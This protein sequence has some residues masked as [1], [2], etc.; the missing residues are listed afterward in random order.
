MATISGWNVCDSDSL[1]TF[2]DHARYSGIGAEEEIM[3]NIHDAVN[4]RYESI[5]QYRVKFKLG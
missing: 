2:E 5:D 4:I 1:V 3:L